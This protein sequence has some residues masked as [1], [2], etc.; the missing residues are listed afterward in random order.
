MSQKGAV[1]IFELNLLPIW[2]QPG[3]CDW[4]PCLLD[5]GI[6]SLVPSANRNREY[7]LQERV[8]GKKGY[9]LVKEDMINEQFYPE[10]AEDWRL[11]GGSRLTI[12]EKQNKVFFIILPHFR[13]KKVET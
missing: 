3:C 5:L 1:Q 10:N 2:V 8:Y 7:Y 13:N 4:C 6:S 12:E 9:E 11:R